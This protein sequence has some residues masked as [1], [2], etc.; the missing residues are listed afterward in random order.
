VFG[1]NDFTSTICKEMA[2]LEC[3]KPGW[4]HEENT[5]PNGERTTGNASPPPLAGTCNT[6]N[7]DCVEF[8]Q[9]AVT[10]SVG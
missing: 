9:Q 3:V 4:W 10:I 6:A 8:Y 7:C 1:V 2:A 5:C